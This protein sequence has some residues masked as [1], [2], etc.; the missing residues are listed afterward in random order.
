LLIA[1]SL[2]WQLVGEFFRFKIIINSALHNGDLGMANSC[3]VCASYLDKEEAGGEKV[4]FS[5]PRCGEFI[6]TRTSKAILP[7]KLEASQEKIA[8]LSYAIRN[9]QSKEKIPVLDSNLITRLLKTK[10]PNPSR[11]ADNFILWLGENLPGPGERITIDG[12]TYQSIIGAKSPKGFALVV[13]HL[14]EK[15]LLVGNISKNLDRTPGQASVTLSM[16]GW[17]CFEE[18]QRSAKDSRKAFMAMK[19]GDETLNRI[20]E[21][22]FKPAVEETGFQLLRLDDLPRAG[23]IDD[24]LRVEIR[25]SRFLIADLTH[26]NAGAYWEAGFAEGLGKPVFYSCEKTKFEKQKTHFDTNHHLTVIWDAENPKE[27]ARNLKATIR[28]TLPDEAKLTD[29]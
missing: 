8:I 15:G 18:L 26:E 7:T 11:Q 1:L 17:D 20:V 24:R 9:M 14:F 27:V 3:P 21:D 29:D 25:T 23:L 12:L 4:L 28:A 22:T 2:K 13:D 16:E 6:L 19:F 5:C 10:L